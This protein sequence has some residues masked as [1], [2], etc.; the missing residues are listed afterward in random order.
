MK[1]KCKEIVIL[2]VSSFHSNFNLSAYLTVKWGCYYYLI[3]EPLV[4]LGCFFFL[5]DIYLIWQI[6]P[7]INVLPSLSRVMKVGKRG[8]VYYS[9]NLCLRNFLAL[10]LEYVVECHWWGNDTSLMYLTRLLLPKVC[11]TDSGFPRLAQG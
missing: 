4:S 9:I 6:Y 7:P 5:T 10:L 8:S 3:T 11:F 1:I 2:F